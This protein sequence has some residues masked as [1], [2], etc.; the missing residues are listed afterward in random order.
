VGSK[1]CSVAASKTAAGK[2]LRAVKNQSKT[3]T[4]KN[5]NEIFPKFLSPSIKTSYEHP[6]SKIETFFGSNLHTPLI[7]EVVFFCPTLGTLSIITYFQ[8]TQL[9]K[10]NPISEMTK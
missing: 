6:A 3:L 10:T 7:I 9:C 4:L 8:Y 5:K 2:S 1:Y